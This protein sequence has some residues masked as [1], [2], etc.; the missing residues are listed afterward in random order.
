[1]LCKKSALCDVTIY[2]F[3]KSI[4]VFGFVIIQSFSSGV[5]VSKIKVCILRPLTQSVNLCECMTVSYSALSRI[6]CFSWSS[7]FKLSTSTFS[8]MFWNKEEQGSGIII[9]HSCSAQN[10]LWLQ[11]HLFCYKRQHFKYHHTNS[12]NHR[13]AFSTTV[14]SL[15]IFHWRKTCVW[16]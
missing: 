14:T 16:L 6:C 8:S 7:C 2:V 9:Q 12:P 13:V 10:N 1:M 4:E 11:K 3:W 5:S 15:Q